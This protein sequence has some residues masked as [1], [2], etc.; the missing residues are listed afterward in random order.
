MWKHKELKLR[1][2]QVLFVPTS[3]EFKKS[4]SA[5]FS[6]SYVFFVESIPE[7]FEDDL[8]S[9]VDDLHSTDDRKSSEE[10]HGPSNC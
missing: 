4:Y 1:I 8:D 2:Y 3:I 9:K 7:D 10:S 6:L 5:A